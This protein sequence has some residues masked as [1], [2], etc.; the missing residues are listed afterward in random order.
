MNENMNTKANTPIGPINP[1]RH[2]KEANGCK[3]IIQL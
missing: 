2:L 3:Y 1:L